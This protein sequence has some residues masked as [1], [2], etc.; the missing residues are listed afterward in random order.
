MVVIYIL[1]Y[2]RCPFIVC[3]LHCLRRCMHA[4]TCVHSEND[5][6][7]NN[8]NPRRRRPPPARRMYVH[9]AA[10]VAHQSRR[11]YIYIHSN[12]NGVCI[13]TQHL[14]C[15][16]VHS[17]HTTPARFGKYKF[18]VFSP[19]P[20]EPASTRTSRAHPLRPRPRPLPRSDHEPPRRFPKPFRAAVAV[21]A[22]SAVAAARS[23]P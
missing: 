15:M 23:S 11:I 4:C 5:S 7:A 22:A 8:G 2:A 10:G 14:V 18:F 13:N 6:E 21:V 19:S 9:A 3:T 1:D 20:S 12:T 17:L 16:Y